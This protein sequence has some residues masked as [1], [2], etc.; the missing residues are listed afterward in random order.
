MLEAIAEEKE[1]KWIKTRV[2]YLYRHCDSGTV[3]CSRI[4]AIALF[5]ETMANA[6]DPENLFSIVFVSGVKLSIFNTL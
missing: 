4:Q 2:K 1:P 5:R 6:F 3:L